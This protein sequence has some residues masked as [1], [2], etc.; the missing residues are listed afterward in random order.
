MK[1]VNL[2]TLLFSGNYDCLQA[3]FHLRRQYGFYMLQAYIPCILIVILSWL[4]FWIN[5]ESVPA[6][7]T[8][9][10]TTVLAM[11]TALSR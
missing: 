3:S 7:I 5:K 6:R 4:S 8:L 2:F 10:V 1:D 11:A 9:G